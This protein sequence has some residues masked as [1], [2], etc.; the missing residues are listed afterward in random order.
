[1]RRIAAGV[2]E[3]KKYHYQNHRICQ[4][5]CDQ[6]V[7]LKPGRVYRVTL[8][9]KEKQQRDGVHAAIPITGTT[10][11]TTTRK[12]SIPNRNNNANNTMNNT[13]TQ[14]RSNNDQEKVK[15][16]QRIVFTY[17]TWDATKNDWR[18][19]TMY[20]SS[21]NKKHFQKKPEYDDQQSSSQHKNQ[22]HQQE[23]SPK[24]RYYYSIPLSR[25]GTLNVFPNLFPK[26]QIYKVK[27][28]LVSC[29]YWRKYSL[30][31][32]DEPRTF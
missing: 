1:M 5:M 3:G 23:Q 21:F 26:Q 14:R 15:Q 2:I 32:G 27:K 9:K 13:Q 12:N 6:K 29:N 24:D 20:T 28:E 16:Q 17:K 10:T 30:Q 25:G 22:Q 4:K 18:P 7:V 19:T 11:M 8:R 31:G